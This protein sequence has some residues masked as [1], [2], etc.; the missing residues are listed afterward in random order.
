METLSKGEFIMT[1]NYYNSLPKLLVAMKNCYQFEN[2]NMYDHG[3]MVAKE[4]SNI[5]TSLEL[6]I[7]SEVF[8]EELIDLYLKYE[9]LDFSIMLN[10]HLLHDC[11]KPLVRIVDEEGRQHFPNHSEASYEQ[12]KLIYPY[13]IDEAFMIKHDMDFHVLKPKELEDLAESKYGFS[14]YL[15][16]WAELIANA[17]MFNGFDS[18]SFKIKRKQ[19]IKCLKLFK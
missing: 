13:N 14:L 3:M 6:G 2:V 11:S 8:P 10:Y 7:I 15:T 17:Q 12:F 1:I 9:L 16:A 5:I 4:Y 18:L 19:L